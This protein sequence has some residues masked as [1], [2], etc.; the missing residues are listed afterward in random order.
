VAGLFGFGWW[1]L[2]A[3]ETQAGFSGN[4]RY[5]VLGSACIEVAGAAGFGWAAL[6]L[7]RA[8]R[9]RAPSPLRRIPRP[10]TLVAAS[11]FMGLVFVFAPNFVG[12]NLIDIQRTHKALV[13]QATLRRNVEALIAADGGRD[14]V[15]ACGSVMTEGFQVPLLA[16]YLNV[17]TV[18]VLD[19]PATDAQGNPIPTKPWP[20]TI[21]QTRATRSAALLPTWQEIHAWEQAGAHYAVRDSK[22]IRF[23]QDCRR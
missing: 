18:R 15:L 16:W 19:Q 7:A 3:L 14:R 12:P 20:N 17:R 8:A 1:I 9:H 13:Y 21:F 6:A 5:L 4:D 10:G 11:G 22:A 23:L 2:I